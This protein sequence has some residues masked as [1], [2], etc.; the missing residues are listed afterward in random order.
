M[1]SL[2]PSAATPEAPLSSSPASLGTALGVASSAS[3]S[4]IAPNPPAGN[5]DDLRRCHLRSATTTCVPFA[6][7]ATGVEIPDA[8]PPA[9][10]RAQKTTCSANDVGAGV[11]AK[12]GAVGEGVGASEPGPVDPT[13]KTEAVGADVG[14]GVGAPV[15]TKVGIAVGSALGY[16]VGAWVGAEVGTGTGTDVGAAVGACV[17]TAVGAGDGASVGT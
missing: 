6:A 7:M 14:A 8:G 16:E 4:K 13:I 2:G 17:G 1:K 12:V 10:R 15:G 11:G 9:I 5:D 3:T